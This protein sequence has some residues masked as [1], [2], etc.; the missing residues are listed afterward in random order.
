MQAEGELQNEK[1]H[2]RKV[3]SGAD[4]A[5]RDF[6]KVVRAWR[7]SLQAEAG[8]L[9]RDSCSGKEGNASCF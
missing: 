3:M 5:W 1:K 7:S 6:F 9:D 8:R 4:G 2:F